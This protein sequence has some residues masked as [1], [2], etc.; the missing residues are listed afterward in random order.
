MCRRSPS[1]SQVPTPV[2][3][4]TAGNSSLLGLIALI[5][6]PIILV[7]LLAIYVHRRRSTEDTFYVRVTPKVGG[8]LHLQF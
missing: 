3:A 1:V 2:N 4:N 5:L 6:I 8:C 7:L